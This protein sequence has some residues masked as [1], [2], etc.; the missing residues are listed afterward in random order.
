LLVDGA[1]RE[2]AAAQLAAAHRPGQGQRGE[3]FAQQAGE[4]FAHGLGRGQPQRATRRRRAVVVETALQ[5]R[6][7]ALAR[8]QEVSSSA[9]SGASACRMCSWSSISWSRSRTPR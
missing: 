1:L 7:A 6:D 4:P 3:A 9:S 5:R 2:R 8:T